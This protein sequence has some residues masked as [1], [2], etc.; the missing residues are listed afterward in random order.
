MEDELN[1]SNEKRTKY[2][3]EFNKEDVNK[4]VIVMGWVLKQRDHGNLIFIDLRD[5]T[6]VLQLT[7]SQEKTNEQTFKEA[8]LC[9]AEFVIIAKGVVNLRKEKN[10]KIKTGEI[11]I[12]VLNLKIISKSKTPPFEI[13]N[14]SNTSL[15]LKLKYRFLE[16]RNEEFQKTFLLRHKITKHTRD[17]F[18][19]NGFLEIETPMLIR[20]TPEGARDYLVP[21]RVHK[22]SF[23]AL[24]QSPQL[25]KQLLMVAGFDRYFQ[26]ARCFRDEDLRADRQPEFSQID[27][28]MSF[29][30][31]EDVMQI[32]EKF[33]ESLFLKILNIK[34]KTPF[35]KMPYQEA[36]QKY[37]TDKPDIRFNLEIKSLKEA[38]LNSNF[39]IFKDA[40]KNGGVFAI[41]LK[42]KADKI[43]RKN[44]D[45]L[46][47]FV[48]T[49][50]A[51]GLFYSKI[52]KDNKTSNF[53][54]F[55]TEEEI[56]LI[57]EKMKAKEN[58][59]IFIISDEKEENA[60]KSLGALRLKLAEDFELYNK[61]EFSFLWVVNFPLF[62]YDEEEER[63]VSKHHPFTAVFEEDMPNLEND[64]G[65]CRSKAYD[66]VLNG[67]EVGG[68]SIR[69]HNKEIQD[70]VFKALKLTE[71][72]IEEKF[73]FLMNAFSF[74]APPHGG[75][76]YGLDRLVMLML[77]KTSIRDVIAFPK[78]QNACELMTN[79]PSRVNEKQLEELNIK[80]KEK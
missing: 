67:C 62:E 54:K 36:M 56:S 55:L 52:L 11:E 72:E 51:K 65:K 23:Y 30:N 3:G 13:N 7:I 42:N 24:P 57:Y 8:A 49:Y 25:Y 78:V 76:A 35:L 61:D 17:F 9:R 10:E 77:K 58:D 75:M 48:K 16:L 80:I 26:I 14:N 69:I 20:S 32:N 33:V 12:N 44:L 60:L 28:E 22:G 27:L 5:R 37:G 6:G 38:V 2:C 29:V 71:K 4:T 31:Q 1:F 15:E 46:T 50:K 47:E 40:L 59:V 64:A 43:S 70:K 45:K 68:G 21:S 63:Y 66:L 79:S 74:G 19:E 18:S 34:I 41:N 73:G 53:E 39:K